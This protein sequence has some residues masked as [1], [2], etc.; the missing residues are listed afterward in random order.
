MTLTE[1]A[2]KHGTAKVGQGFMPLYEKILEPIRHMDICLLEIGLAEGASLRTWR[3]YL[4]R[5][6]IW[7]LD[8]VVMCQVEGCRIAQGDGCDKNVLVKLGIKAEVPF[9]DIIIDDAYHRAAEQLATF[10]NLW[11]KVLPD[12]WY[13]IEDLFTLFDPVWNPSGRNILDELYSRMGTMMTGQD[14]IKEIH[15]YVNGETDGIVFI[16]KNG[17]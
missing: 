7:G 2:T 11:P 4:K 5:A 10:D 14:E 12:G 17:R 16:R 8:K 9:W 1:I 3:E 13:V 6:Y 15:F